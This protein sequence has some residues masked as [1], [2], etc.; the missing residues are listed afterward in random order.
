MRQRD[1][2][3]VQVFIENV[4]HI[5]SECQYPFNRVLKA[6]KSVDFP[7][8]MPS[9]LAKSMSAALGGLFDGP[10]T[11]NRN[12]YSTFTKELSTLEK[13]GMH[14][15]NWYLKYVGSFSWIACLSNRKITVMQMRIFE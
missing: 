15:E 9:G 8:G 12:N 14:V 2:S 7:P 5:F 13:I 1:R 6:V 3:F 11:D 10:R 4:M